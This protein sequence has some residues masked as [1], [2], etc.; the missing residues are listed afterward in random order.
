M[1]K[2]IAIFI[3]AIGILFLCGM[4]IQFRQDYWERQR[5]VLDQKALTE[6]HTE[7]LERTRKTPCT[8]RSQYVSLLEIYNKTKK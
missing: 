1:K 4:C 8:N 5:H 3:I 7:F 2:A 6:N